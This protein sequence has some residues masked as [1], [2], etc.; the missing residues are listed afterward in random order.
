MEYLLDQ[1]VS[2]RLE[3]FQK[4]L[5]RNDLDGALVLQNVGIYYYTGTA[6]ASFLFIPGQGEPMLMVKKSF[7]RARK[8]SPH[9]NILQVNGKRDMAEMIKDSGLK[10]D[11]ALG[12]EMDLV[13][14]SMYLWLRE[15]FPGVLWKD[16]SSLLRTQRM[17]KSAYETDQIRTA[18]QIEH[19]VFTDLRTF[20]KE[21]MIELE[22]DARLA[23]LARRK[24][25]QGI[26]RMRGWN[27]EMTYAHVLSG[28]N[29]AVSSYLNSAHGGTG[30]NPAMPQ[31]AG[32]RR[33]GRNEPIL[34]D[35]SVGINGYIGDQSRAYVI[36]DL[37]EKLQKAH[38]CSRRILDRFSRL[39][40]PGVLCSHLYQIA[41]ETADEEGFSRFF[42][43]HGNGQVGFIGHG[44]GLEIDE[45][46]VITPGF[47]KPLQEGMVLALEPK[48]VFPGEG[49]VG[50]EDDYVVTE[51]GVERIT[52]TEQD[53]LRVEE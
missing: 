45:L 35:Y 44:I 46:P 52:L 1:E 18:C 37:P 20:I 29:G 40:K 8:E 47:D 49:A 6:Q 5:G 27:Q 4:L 50:I 41:W 23:S 53:V 34:V 13:P 38:D 32:F 24:G 3:T 2:T 30:T 11:A 15:T 21:G 25:H 19:E 28:D 48:F 36:G 26:V 39:A 9:K 42:M 43:G 33:I 31:G 17:I 10:P 7:E 51:T 12:L 16:I 22:V 14:A